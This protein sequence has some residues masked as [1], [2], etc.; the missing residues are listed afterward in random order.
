MGMRIEGE[1]LVGVILV[2]VDAA[3]KRILMPRRKRNDLNRGRFQAQ[4]MSLEKSCAWAETS[5]PTKMDGHGY[6]NN[7]K[8]QL[9]PAELRVRKTCFEKALKWVNNAPANGYVVDTPLKPTFSPYPPIRDVRVDGE[10][11]AGASFKDN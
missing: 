6:L 9:T 2:M 7:L 10:L 1:S 8:D 3:I 4:G 5:I 11:Y